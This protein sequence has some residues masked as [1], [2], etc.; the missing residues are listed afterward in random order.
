[1]ESVNIGSKYISHCRYSRTNVRVSG[2]ES[3]ELLKK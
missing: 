2:I 1:M 3:D